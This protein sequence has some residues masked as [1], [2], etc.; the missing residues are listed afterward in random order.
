MGRPH[1]PCDPTRPCTRCGKD[2]RPEQLAK[3]SSAIDGLHT[4]CIACKSSYDADYRAR[5]SEIILQQKRDYY[6][7]K[8]AEDPNY[9]LQK[10]KDEMERYR[11]NPEPWKRSKA[12]YISRNG[13]RERS[14]AQAKQYRERPEVRERLRSHH[15][16]RSFRLTTEQ[17][18][19]MF[20]SQGKRCAIC[21]ADSP[22][23]RNAWHTDHDHHTGIVRGILCAHCNRGL[24]G[25]RDSVTTL[26]AM[27][28]YLT[29]SSTPRPS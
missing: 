28:E 1:I 2:C 22:G 9:R 21:R 14:V 23:T 6:A 29:K 4:W 11:S 16:M 8:C 17:W 5:N 27:V 24:G 20:E 13:V 25:A 12:K 19:A 7:R 10:S 3:R 18:T 26:N 15:L